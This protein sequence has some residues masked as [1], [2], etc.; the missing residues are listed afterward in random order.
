MT[1]DTKK[2]PPKTVLDTNIIVSALVFGGKPRQI[3]KLI[4]SKQLEAVISLSLFTELTEIL[5][6]KF[7]FSS[8]KIHFLEQKIKKYFQIVYPTKTIN[9][10][11]DLADNRVLEA[12]IAGDCQFVISGDKELLELKQYRNIKILTASQ[13][14]EI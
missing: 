12:A 14:L 6:K 13:F 2:A 10:L 5:V 4:L 1:T 8:D 9:I 7:N 3:F 11:K